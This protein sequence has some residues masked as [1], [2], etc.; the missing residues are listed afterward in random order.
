MA[1]TPCFCRTQSTHAVRSAGQT[2]PTAE[3]NSLSAAAQCAA[4]AHAMPWSGAGQKGGGA[5]W[6]GLEREGSGLP[7]QS[8]SALGSEGCAEGGSA[9]PMVSENGRVSR[10]SAHHAAH[11]S[12]ALQ[13]AGAARG[14]R[15]RAASHCATARTHARYRLDSSRSCGA[16]PFA[17]TNGR[18]LRLRCAA[19]PPTVRC[20]ERCRCAAHCAVKLT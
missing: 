18:G 8:R 7:E 12:A 19:R 13:R 1:P 6:S 3:G 9:D 16:V 11:R 10:A 17:T 15:L 5:G 2:R 20:G 4:A 14:R